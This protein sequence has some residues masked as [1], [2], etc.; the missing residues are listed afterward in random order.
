VDRRYTLDDATVVM[1]ER[2]FAWPILV[3][4]QSG[5]TLTCSVT[6]TMT[7]T[8]GPLVLDKALFTLRAK[9]RT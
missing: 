5:D 3:E 7:L 2:A 4:A 1:G 9:R 8:S 6:G